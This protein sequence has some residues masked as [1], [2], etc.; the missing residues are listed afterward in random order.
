MPALTIAFCT[1]NRADRLSRLVRLLREQA[2]PVPF[3]ILAINNNSRDDTSDVLR[4][5][6]QQ[7]GAA[8]R[9]VTED[10]PGI[11]PARNRAI[12]EALD[13][14]IM[15]FIDDDELPEPGWL[16]A[17]YDAL[18]IEQ[19]QCVGG[20]I[21][22]DYSGHVRP[23]WMD[24]ELEGFLGRLDHGDE[25]FWIRHDTT[26]VWS[27]NIAYDMRLFRDDPT[28]RFDARYNR[29]GNGL[30]GGEDAMMFRSL[31]ARQVPIRYRPDMAIL[32]SVDAWKL[33]RSYFLKLH[34]QA[35]VR[36]GQHALPDYARTLLGV[37]PFLV[38]QFLR[39]AAKTLKMQL[40]GQ[41]GT[42]RQAMNAAHALG[43]LQGY[44]ARA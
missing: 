1:Y 20:R 40:S 7:P 33:R 14:D 9:F 37:P 25:A 38:G 13:S 26:P 21:R 5:L 3:D 23:D 15:A 24:T 22:V 42:L 8:L 28:L 43:S 39:Q 27:G 17:V 10:K 34:Y 6:Q 12:A 11:V 4:A 32:H 41:P 19:A 36:A 31:L 18:S 16:A 2:C 30:G 29:S 44:R 35:G